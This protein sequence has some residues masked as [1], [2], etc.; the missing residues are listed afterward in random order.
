MTLSLCLLS[1][2]VMGPTG[3]GKSTF[4]STLAS[5]HE[6]TME[7]QIGHDLKS[8]TAKIQAVPFHILQGPLEGWQVVMV[9]MPG[10]NNT[11]L[12][13]AENL[14]RIALWLALLY[15]SKMKLA[16]II[17]LYD[18]SQA[19]MLGT[20]LNNM[21]MFEKLCG[22]K[23]LE[24][25]ILM[26]TKWSFMDSNTGKSHEEQLQKEFWGPTVKNKS[27]VYQFDRSPESARYVLEMLCTTYKSC[28]KAMILQIQAEVVDMAKRIPNTEAG[29]ELRYTL[30]ELLD[31]QKSHS[32]NDNEIQ[33]ILRQLKALKI[34]LSQRFLGFL[35]LAV[36]RL[37]CWHYKKSCFTDLFLLIVIYC[38]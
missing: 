10:F 22:E 11:Y 1:P 3:V 13:D 26:T 15:H 2:S 19:W 8:C 12:D 25:V 35:G 28:Q 5:S 16:G 38:Q 33:K 17:Y 18:I 7:V 20:T 31:M 21:Q 9:D 30:Q 24:A 6:N 36:R 29:R 27:Q 14:K 23:V 37:I 34:P 32:R 4:I